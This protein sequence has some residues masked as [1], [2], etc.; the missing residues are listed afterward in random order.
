MTQYHIV[1]EI[2][3]QLKVIEATIVTMMAIIN[4]KTQNLNWAD[5]LRIVLRSY[6]LKPT[7]KD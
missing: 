7:K 3:P 4:I 1:V 2:L 5:R 6:W